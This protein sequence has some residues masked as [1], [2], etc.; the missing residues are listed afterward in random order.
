MIYTKLY[1]S[2]LDSTNMNMFVDH[3]TTL[4]HSVFV[5]LAVNSLHRLSFQL[6]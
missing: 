5:N 2:H 1:S 6:S 3:V 4:T